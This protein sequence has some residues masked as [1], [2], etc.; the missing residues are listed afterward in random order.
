MSDTFADGTDQMAIKKLACES[1]GGQLIIDEMKQN[2]IC[3]FCGV[4]Y[5]YEYFREDDI[6]TKA[7]R[8]LH[9]HEFKAAR[10]A[11][12]FLLEKEP[13]N[14]YAREKLLL[15]QYHLRGVEDIVKTDVR[16]WHEADPE[17][18]DR[19]V[20]GSEELTKLRELI[21]SRLYAQELDLKVEELDSVIASEETRLLT[22]TDLAAGCYSGK[23]G[24]R[25]TI[26]AIRKDH[27]RIFVITVLCTILLLTPGALASMDHFPLNFFLM[28]YT[29]CVAALV[30]GLDYHNKAKRLKT[31]ENALKKRE[32][33]ITSL[34]KHREERAALQEGSD[35]IKERVEQ[36]VRVFIRT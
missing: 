17:E 22:L 35:G 2:Y 1:C 25:L 23:T 15:S 8:Y 24:E 9:R 29:I 19:I 20:S 31:A 32:E 6:H 12:E 7:E 34:S 36:E 18:V 21:D 26:S 3:Q 30:I 27:I 33:L 14:S 5:D 16:L 10:E 28:A 4:T 11:L 13:S